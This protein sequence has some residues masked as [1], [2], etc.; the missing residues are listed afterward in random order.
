MFLRRKF[1][2]PPLSGQLPTLRQETCRYQKER[3]S[4]LVQRASR[5]LRPHLISPRPRPPRNGWIKPNLFQSR[6]EQH[7]FA[8]CVSRRHL[9]VNIEIRFL[10]HG[11]GRRFDAPMPKI[12]TPADTCRRGRAVV[13]LEL[14]FKPKSANYVGCVPLRI[15]KGK[16]TFSGLPFLKESTMNFRTLGD[17]RRERRLGLRTIPNPNE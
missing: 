11:H 1:T 15:S 13:E 9:L 6:S 7:I 16:K 10:R 2:I 17:L 5:P 12:P 3:T 14:P 4:L 8:L